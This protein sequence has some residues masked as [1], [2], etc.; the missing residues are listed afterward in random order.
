MTRHYPDLGKRQDQS[1]AVPRSGQRRVISMEFL[2][3]F[4]SCHFARKP[5]VAS[6]NAVCFL[7]LAITRLTR[8][9]VNLSR[10]CV[11]GSVD[12]KMPTQAKVKR[13]KCFHLSRTVRETYFVGIK[14]VSKVKSSSKASLLPP[15]KYCL[16][17]K[18]LVQIFSFFDQKV[19]MKLGT[20][21]KYSF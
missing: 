18:F 20:E 2:R 9:H 1:E 13:K 16:R 15:R 17:M 10:F 12:V 14:R 11:V 6:R 7:R 5:L 19:L 21:R 3:L 4:F 8:T